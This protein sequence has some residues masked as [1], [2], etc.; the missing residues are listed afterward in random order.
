MSIWDDITKPFKSRTFRSGLLKYPTKFVVGCTTCSGTVTLEIPAGKAEP[1][2][3]VTCLGCGKD[4]SL[5]VVG[6][7]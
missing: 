2:V 7:G 3:L 5:Y 1:S 6:P 4:E